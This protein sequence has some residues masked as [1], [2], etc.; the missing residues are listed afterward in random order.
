MYSQGESADF[1]ELCL[2]GIELFLDVDAV[3]TTQELIDADILVMA[4]GCFSYCAGL[5]SDG[6]KI[7]EPIIL[8]GTDCLPSWKWRALPLAESWISSQPD[9]SFNRAAFERQ[10]VAVLQ[11]RALPPTHASTGASHIAVENCDCLQ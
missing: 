7:F 10:L 11:A 8:S 2:P 9:G 5:L 6:I 3:W 4:M 1:A